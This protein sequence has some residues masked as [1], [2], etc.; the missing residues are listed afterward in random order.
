MVVSLALDNEGKISIDNVLQKID[1]NRM[2]SA[3]G[4]S[5]YDYNI[6]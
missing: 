2:T 4:K 6:E 3:Y 1:A 5:N